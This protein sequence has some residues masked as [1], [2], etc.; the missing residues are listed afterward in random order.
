MENNKHGWETKSYKLESNEWTST[1][2]SEKKKI[3]NNKFSDSSTTKYYLMT[4]FF[5]VGLMTVSI[6]KNETRNLQK[7]IGLLQTS[8]NIVKHDLYQSTLEHAVITSPE[9]ISILAKEYLDS[10]FLAYK[11]IQIK[12]LNSEKKISSI[13]KN[14][15][16]KNIKEKSQ[17]MLAKKVESKK[18]ELISLKKFYYNPKIIPGEVKTRVS[19]KI[20]IAKD[21]MKALYNDPK[22]GFRTKRIYKWGAVQVVKVMLGI[23]VVPGK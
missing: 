9:N 15:K 4:I 11:N 10:S 13:L 6:I 3:L 23:P 21:E 5:I 18:N 1:L 20:E 12:K 7:E 2:P 8:I 19:K 16:K 22:E 14:N 17:L